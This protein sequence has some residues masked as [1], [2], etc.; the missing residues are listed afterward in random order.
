MPSVHLLKKLALAT[1]GEP[2]KV[3]IPE[4]A[5]AVSWIK[6]KLLEVA[7]IGR[8][9]L[10][11]CHHQLAVGPS[12]YPAENAVHGAKAGRAEQMIVLKGL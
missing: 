7:G 3:T 6:G 2:A 4:T 12:A 9:A 5:L 11:Q 1:E 8:F 10:V